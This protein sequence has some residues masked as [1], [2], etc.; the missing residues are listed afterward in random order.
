MK[1]KHLIYP[2]IFSGMLFLA[3]CSQKAVTPE[4]PKPEPVNLSRTESQNFMNSEVSTMNSQMTEANN[5]NGAKALKGLTNAS[6]G[7]SF[8]ISPAKLDMGESISLTISKSLLQMVKSNA[9]SQTNARL[10]QPIYRYKGIY[11]FDNVNNVFPETPDQA[12]EDLIFIFPDSINNVTN[13]SNNCKLVVKDFETTFVTR[14]GK[15][16]QDTLPTKVNFTLFYNDVVESTF[17]MTGSYQSDGIPKAVSANLYVRPFRLTEN[18]TYASD[19]ASYSTNFKNESSNIEITGA[20]INATGNINKQE[21]NSVNGNMFLFGLQVNMDIN[22]REIIKIQSNSNTLSQEDYAK[23]VNVSLV[24]KSDQASIGKI[25]VK[26]NTIREP[27]NSY[28]P[29]NQGNYVPCVQYTSYSRTD[30]YIKHSSDNSEEKL[31]DFAEGF[32][33]NFKIPSNWSNR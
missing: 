5:C 20:T 19:K 9:S 13:G 25:L 4:K 28:C 29:D 17:S 8:S 22:V 18:L 27:Y 14:N 15:T 2:S 1:T 32:A 26:S 10:D 11:T 21:Y 16:K 12:S 23:Y 7:P 6:G 33:N 30:A 3:N 31:Q 24:R